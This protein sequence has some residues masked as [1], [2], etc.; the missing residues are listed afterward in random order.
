MN[1]IVGRAEVLVIE[2]LSY[3]EETGNTEIFVDTIRTM[4][5]EGPDAFDAT[6]REFLSHIAECVA[7]G[8]D[9]GS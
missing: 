2:L 6:R 1:D 9:G 7:A 4:V 3:M 8:V 5:L